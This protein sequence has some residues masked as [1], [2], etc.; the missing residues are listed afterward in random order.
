V[1]ED[2]K[3]HEERRK[4]G[5]IEHTACRRAVPA[6]G[7]VVVRLSTRLRPMWPYL[8]PA[9]TQATRMVAPITVRASSLRGGYLPTGHVESMEEA[10]ATTGG[11]CVTVR[12]PE[13][14]T[15]TLPKGFPDRSADYVPWLSEHVRRVALAELPH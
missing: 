11:R 4:R 6:P 10:A 5:R 12:Q 13:M 8:K 9:Y 15:R 7:V 3:T 2:T 14:R 1:W